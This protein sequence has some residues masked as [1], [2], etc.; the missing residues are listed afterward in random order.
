MNPNFKHFTDETFRKDKQKL[1]AL[2]SVRDEED[3]I[4]PQFFAFGA[5]EFNV[6]VLFHWQTGSTVFIFIGNV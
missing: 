6:Q 2:L 3:P 4:L 5:G 1:F